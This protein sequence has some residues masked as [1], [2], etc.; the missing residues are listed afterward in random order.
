MREEGGVSGERVEEGISTPNQ[1]EQ[2]LTSW[3]K[4]GLTGTDT[5]SHGLQVCPYKL[6][7]THT[8]LQNPSLVIAI[9]F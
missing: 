8:L 4:P 7:H 2:Q 3:L 6:T 1:R 5:R 9:K